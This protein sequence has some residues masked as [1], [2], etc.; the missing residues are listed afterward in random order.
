MQH[1]LSNPFKQALLAGNTQ[2]GLWLSCANSYT[3]EIA[4]TAGYDWLLLDGEHGPNDIPTLLGQLQAVAPY[5]GQAVVRP[6]NGDPALIKQVLDIGAQTLLIPMVDTAAAAQALVA[7]TRYPPLGIRGVGASVARAARWGRV[8]DYM[9]HA[10]ELICL[11]VQ[12]ET[13][14]ALGNLDEIAQVDGVDGVFIGPADLSASMGHP[15]NAG[16][17]EVQFAI[18]DAIKRIRR[19]GKA[20]G[21]LATDTVSAQRYL[22]WGAHFVAIGVDTML[23]SQALDAAIAPFRAGQ[24]AAVPVASY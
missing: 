17:P 6:V 5:T 24:R 16:H 8:S 22:D 23:F 18:C 3:A 2:L 4:A 1:E 15:G 7:A 19:Q 11:L 20:A 13:I 10:D 21:I 9:H 14:T 12:A